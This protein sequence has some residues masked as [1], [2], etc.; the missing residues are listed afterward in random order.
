MGADDPVGLPAGQDPSGQTFPRRTSAGSSWG[1]RGAR[2]RSHSRTTCQPLII[3]GQIHPLPVDTTIPGANQA[4]QTGQP[5]TCTAAWSPGSA[6]ADPSTGLTP[7]GATGSSFLNNKVFNPVASSRRRR[8]LL[9]HEP[10]RPVHVVSRPCR[11]HH[12]AQRLCRNCLRHADPRQVRSGSGRNNGLPHYIEVL[13]GNVRNSRSSSRTRSSSDPDIDDD[14]R[15]HRNWICKPLQNPG[16][17]WYAHT[18]EP[19]TDG[20]GRWD[21]VSNFTLP[22]S[23]EHPRVLRRHHAGQRTTFPETTVQARRYRLRMLNACNARFLNL[24]LYIDDGSPNGITLNPTTGFP[25]QYA[26]RQRRYGRLL[27]AADRHRGGLPV[28]TGESPEQHAFCDSMIPPDSDSR[29]RLN[30]PSS[31]VPA[32]GAGGTAGPHRRFQQRS[33][34]STARTRA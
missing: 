10:E 30:P 34:E 25:D 1:R 24:Q 26:I 8:V 33:E 31:E 13:G 5:S 32:R 12:P 7:T 23:L 20:I 6:T 21:L 22:G 2:S 29:G 9:P 27:L 11:R 18:Y 3:L 17:L 14:P 4:S 28:D 19:T 15:W 16:S